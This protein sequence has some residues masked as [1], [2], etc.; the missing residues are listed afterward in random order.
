[1]RK[2]KFFTPYQKSGKTTFPE[3][4]QKSGV[5]LIK[6]NDRLVYIGMSATNLYKTLYR[7]FEVWNHR[8][9]QVVSYKSRMAKNKY[10][11]RVILCT[12]NQAVK[13]E[14]AL[15]KKHKPRDNENKYARY[16]ITL[17]DLNLVKQYEETEVW[18][19]PPF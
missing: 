8:T 6:E 19:D 1:M 3:T 18:P 16:E 5:Y 17:P 2:Y 9:Q 15:I 13:L 14:R 7:H 11:V 10:T 12:S 4:Q